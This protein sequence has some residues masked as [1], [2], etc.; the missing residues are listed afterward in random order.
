MG[1]ANQSHPLVT[2]LWVHQICFNFF[3]LK[4]AVLE[5]EK[6][7]ISIFACYSV[8]CVLFSLFI[9]KANPTGPGGLWVL[10]YMI[11]MIINITYEIPPL[12]FCGPQQ[13]KE[14]YVCVDYL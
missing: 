3:V 12:C 1:V 2:R 10:K 6:K 4:R 7:I 8:I 14:N 11:L 9:T 5:V 13:I